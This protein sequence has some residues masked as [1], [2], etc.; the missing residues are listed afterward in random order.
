MYASVK[1]KE[2]M[3]NPPDTIESQEEMEV[4][5]QKFDETGAW[6]LPVLEKNK[7]LGFISKSSLLSQYRQILKKEEE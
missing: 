2:I 4:V 3:T 6:T 5:M 7:Y 1:A